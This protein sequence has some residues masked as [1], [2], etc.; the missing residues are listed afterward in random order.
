MDGFFDVTGRDLEL[1]TPNSAVKSFR[2]LLH[3]EA[4]SMRLSPSKVQIYESI[5]SPDGGI[6]AVVDNVGED[7]GSRLIHPGLNCYQIKTGTESPNVRSNVQKIL[8]KA[9]KKTLHPNVKSCLDQ[10]GF[11]AVV[12][13][14]SDRP[15]KN[16]NAAQMFKDELKKKHPKYVRP[17][18]E[19]WQQSQIIGFLKKFPSLRRQ[20][21]NTSQFPCFLHNEW[22][23]QHQDMQTKFVAGEAQQNFINQIRGK[24]GLNNPESNIRI[25]GSPGSGKTR[26]A[27]EITD[28][29]ELS[30]LVIYFKNPDH[31]RRDNFLSR[32]L[33]SHCHAI[34]IVD[35]CDRDARMNLWNMVSTSSGLKLITIYN[36]RSESETYGLPL[37][38][39]TK[40]AE[41]LSNYVPKDV[42]GQ[43]APWCTPSPR[44]ANWLGQKMR[45]DRNFC[46]LSEDAIY[47][48][49]IA[50]KLQLE[51]QE[52]KHRRSVLMWISIFVR[53]GHGGQYRE[54]SNALAQKIKQEHS[55][56]KGDFN[57]IVSELIEEK[58]LQGHNTLY[59]SPSLVHLWLWR[60]WWQIHGD[61]LDVNK[62]LLVDGT[63]T[64]P[65]FFP[66]SMQD[67]FLN[68]F[69][70]AEESRNAMEVAQRFLGVDGPL[71]DGK[72]LETYE[73][74]RFFSALAHA[75][76]KMSLDLLDRTI[77]KW[78]LQRLL[79]FTVGRREIMWRLEDLVRE[80]SNFEVAAKILLRLS[81]AENE[82]VAN[83]ATNVFAEL[84]SV[85]SGEL[86]RTQATT[87]TKLSLLSR[88]LD[89]PDKKERICALKACNMALESLHFTKTDYRRG[90]VLLRISKEWDPGQMEINTYQTVIKL[91]TSRLQQMESDERQEAICIILKRANAL[92]RLE[93]LAKLLTDTIW[94]ISQK[95]YADPEK[96][97]SEVESIIY[98]DRENLDPAI[99]GMWEKLRGNL[100]KDDYRSLLKRYVGMDI[101]TDNLDENRRKTG[102]VSNRI[103][104]IASE[105]MR[106]KEKLLAELEWICITN[107]RPAAVFGYELG[108][109]DV[110]FSLLPS[111]L[112]A[113]AAVA[114]NHSGTFLGNYL[115]AIF[116]KD[117]KQWELILDS[118]AENPDLCK[119]V[120]DVT[121]LSGMTDQAGLRIV[122]L[123]NKDIVKKVDL[124]A[125]VYRSRLLDLSE[126]V[127]LKWI[128]MLLD[129]RDI[130]SLN[131][132][133]ALF[134][135][136]YIRGNSTRVL[137]EKTA[138]RLISHELLLRESTNP[139]YATV[140]KFCW[141]SIAIK[142][143][144]QAPER[145]IS[146][147]DI[148]L[149]SMGNRNNIFSGY[150]SETL[151]V[152][153]LISMSKPTTIWE[154]V[155]KYI[156]PPL[157]KRAFAVLT[158]LEGSDG[159]R[160]T[161]AFM[162]IPLTQ[163]FDWIDADK[164]KRSR[165]MARFIPKIPFDR[166]LCVVREFLVNYGDS[167]D[168]RVAL[169]NHFLSGAWRGSSVKHYTQEMEKYTAIKE[170]ET[171]SN[172][173]RWI[174]DHVEILKRR[175]ESEMDAEERL[176]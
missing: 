90:K 151:K 152:L 130:E 42:S 88:I 75:E 56:S 119:H 7:R 60:K 68:M 83:N 73:G 141:T 31:V 135:W 26:I 124:F 74:A 4:Y 58:I 34:L 128:G 168:V 172:V 14:G 102:Q 89:S 146:L 137:P 59:I 12:S 6:D 36:E 3:A 69:A 48:R 9:D 5:N 84:F 94:E 22:R 8:F 62:L 176:L 127:F 92:T 131:V 136:Y 70:Y 138:F 132:A 38:T 40:I 155:H 67:G 27:Y 2:D 158:W 65:V 139:K 15:P 87:E 109:M 32:L 44:L 115:R 98:F 140:D 49:F 154:I 61:G 29:E 125:F 156:G 17:R 144:E 105:S 121:A 169:H 24:L 55:I 104:K 82:D 80:P 166:K 97:I 165:H 116:E 91:L 157:D 120:V 129:A 174:D 143:I 175:I 66:Q 45:E 30:S 28:T 79:D 1:L 78:D 57:D 41:I 50:G 171:N 47:T 149:K 71:D 18:I 122:R 147:A 53:V 96:L 112:R 107:T 110:D 150:G 85:A 159:G 126:T 162:A 86:A 43:Y 145:A 160:S 35:E 123:C 99:M 173:I 118:M 101:F 93:P 161:P 111:I 76:P 100:Q 142:F 10:G 25:G 19:V 13:F 148:F 164:D 106:F 77:G 113:Q 39:E 33:G 81:V 51:S 163:I 134:E 64:P 117:A 108:R 133:L 52:F 16:M 114:S 21:T 153:D 46:A 37:L 103:R 170:H 20:L 72:L 63:V 23:D 167:D 11:F 54:E 95:P